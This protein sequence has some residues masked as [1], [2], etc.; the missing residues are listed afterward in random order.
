[1]YFP[2]DMEE[3]DKRVARLTLSKFD[4]RHATLSLPLF[5]WSQRQI[6]PWNEQEPDRMGREA[7]RE[8]NDKLATAA[9]DLEARLS[10]LPAL[11]PAVETTDVNEEWTQLGLYA[12][13]DLGPGSTILEERSMLTAIR[14]HGE[15][16]CDAC[17][18]DMESIPAT[19]RR[20]CEGCNIPFCSEECHSTATARYHIPNEQDEETDEGY[21]PAASPFCPGT[22]G[23]DDLHNLGRAESSTTPEWDLYFLL[24]SRTL[25]MAETEQTQP[26]DLFEV[27]YLWGDFTSTPDVNDL[28]KGGRQK[29]T[30]IQREASCRT[31]SPVVRDP[32]ALSSRVSTVQRHLAGE[33]RLVDR[34]DALCQVPRRR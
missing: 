2:V 32:D 26:L 9:P 19:D 8:I 30:T 7:L 33:V 10:T 5:G 21:P 22:V 31:S 29:H 13:K 25:Q 24:L 34:A 20:Y 27:K 4:R 1:M 15:A 6:Y 11:T 3:L 16:L 28:D 17:A 23:N 12:K 18:A 14:P